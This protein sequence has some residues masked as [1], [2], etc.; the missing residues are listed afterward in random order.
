MAQSAAGGAM[1]NL[2]SAGPIAE[3]AIAGGLVDVTVQDSQA[4]GTSGSR[5]LRL[6]VIGP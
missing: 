3:T 6:R 4:L 2:G 1:S 5:F